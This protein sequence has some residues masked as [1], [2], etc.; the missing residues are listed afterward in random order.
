M[1]EQTCCFTG[2]RNI[3]PEQYAA[4]AERLRT[5]VIDLIEA[6]ICRFCAGGAL[7]FDTLAAQTV[8]ALKEKYSHIQLILMLPCTTQTKGWPPGD[9]QIYKSIQQRCDRFFTSLRHTRVD[10][11]S[12]VTVVWWITAASASAI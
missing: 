11:C 9:I 2:H 3:P 7:G 12:S 5:A 10:A 1:K 8:L 6:G 4:I